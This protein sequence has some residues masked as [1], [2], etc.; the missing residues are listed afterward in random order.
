MG[1]FDLFKTKMDKDAYA[2]PANPMHDILFVT[3]CQKFQSE[4]KAPVDTVLVG[5]SITAGAEVFSQYFPGAVNQGIPGDTTLDVRKRI[6]IIVE[7][8]PKKI[9]LL[10]GTNNIGS[11]LISDAQCKKDYPSV[12]NKLITDY[13]EIL[14]TFKNNLPYTDVYVQSILPINPIMIGTV[15]TGR[16]NIIVQQINEVLSH[17][18]Q[19]YDRAYFLN[20]Y[21]SFL[22]ASGQYMNSKYTDDGLHPNEVGYKLWGSIISKLF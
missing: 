15:V 14:N 7:K 12:S 16:T 4:Q 18:N 5:D 22:E 3:R 21:P 19:L 13:I 2:I 9:F 10:I 8:Q 17:V 20:L 6:N 11:W 1:L